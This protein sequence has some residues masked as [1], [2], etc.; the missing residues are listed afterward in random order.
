MTKIQRV[1]HQWK[2]FMQNMPPVIYPWKGISMN[3]TWHNIKVAYNSKSYSRVTHQWKEFMQNMPPVIYLWREITV[4]LT[5]RT[6][7]SSGHPRQ[8]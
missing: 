1:T 8:F 4:N 2:G 7:L 6:H 5:W 3:L